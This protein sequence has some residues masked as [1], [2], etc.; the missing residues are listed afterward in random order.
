MAEGWGYRQRIGAVHVARA[1]DAVTVRVRLGDRP[2]L[3]LALRDPEPL[4]P[5]DVQYTAG[6]HLAH[7]AR[8]LRLVQV[9]PTYDVTRAERARP[10]CLALDGAGWGDA[11][12][13]AGH[14]VSASIVLADVTL[15]K[16]RYVCRP[17]VWAFDGTERV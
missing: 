11:R 4:G 3:E 9:D 12:V 10:R 17:D 5:H 13:V 2:I 7:T 8:G 6:M 15:P 1:Y 16:L 14:P